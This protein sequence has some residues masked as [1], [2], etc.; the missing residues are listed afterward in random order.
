MFHA[1]NTSEQIDK[2]VSTILDWASEM[3][4][5]EKGAVTHALPEAA[6]QVYSMQIVN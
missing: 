5:I 6:R 3:L 4:D 2:L 1:H